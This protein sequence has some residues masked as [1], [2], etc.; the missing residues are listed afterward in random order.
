MTSS[1]YAAATPHY[2]AAMSSSP[3][4]RVV[5]AIPGAIGLAVII[6]NEDYTSSPPALGLVSLPGAARDGQV[7]SQALTRLN[8]AVHHVRN[9]S[10]HAL[11]QVVYEISHLKYHMVR[12]YRCIMFV[13]AGHGC[14]GD[15]LYMP[16]GARVHLGEEI[17]TPLLPG[18]ANDIGG[19]PKVFLID[20]CRGSK[21]TD[22]V[23]VPRGI[24]LNN[25]G[26]SLMERVKVTAMGEYLLAYSTMPRHKAFEVERQGGVWLST[27]ARLLNERR[28]LD[29]LENLLTK[30]NE[31]IQERLQGTGNFQQ[32]EKYSRINKIISLDPN[33]ESRCFRVDPLP[34]FITL[35]VGRGADCRQQITSGGATCGGQVAPSKSCY[36][37]YYCL[38]TKP[39]MGYYNY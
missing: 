39:F 22:T 23:F 11:R 30:V 3:V 38:Q 36:H 7:L 15:L 13:Y 12:D 5:R 20:A 9:T 26:G 16:E 21:D 29:S 18:S 37:T 1:V 24:R 31:E 6:T 35:G 19:I 4:E 28:Y 10:H 34:V 14:E 32:P 27:L 33:G 2:P 8:F 17:I 25:R